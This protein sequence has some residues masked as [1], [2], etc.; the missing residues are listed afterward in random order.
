MSENLDPGRHPFIDPKTVDHSD[1]LLTSGL[2]KATELGAILVD[3]P[4]VILP[5]LKSRLC[6]GKG[7]IGLARHAGERPLFRDRTVR[8][9]TGSAHFPFPDDRVLVMWILHW[10]TPGQGTDWM[11]EKLSNLHRASDRS[12]LHPSPC[13][14]VCAGRSSSGA[15][16]HW[17]GSSSCRDRG[18]STW[19]APT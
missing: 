12:R 7:P 15:P 14:T 5:E 2:R 4:E 17:T 16:E 10:W 1:C 8:D 19:R 6:H 3:R 13:G 18:S 9:A 11:S